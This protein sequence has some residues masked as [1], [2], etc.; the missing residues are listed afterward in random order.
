[1]KT[2]KI[3]LIEIGR[4]KHSGEFIKK[5]QSFDNAGD[6]VYK[7]V[8]KHLYSRNSIE[9]NFNEDLNCYIVFAGFQTVGKVKIEEIA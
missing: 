9:L 7:E 8:L 5:F 3:S 1:M 6:F 2:F 4:N